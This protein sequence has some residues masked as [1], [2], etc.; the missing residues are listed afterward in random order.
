MNRGRTNATSLVHRRIILLPFLALYVSMAVAQTKPFTND[1]ATFLQDITAFMVE[2]DKKEGKPFMEQEFAP[3]W[4]GTFFGAPQRSRVVELANVML[5]K[6][7]EAFPGFRDYLGSLVAFAGGGRSAADFDTYMT[8]LE[9]A[10]KSSRKQNLTDLIS[11]SANLFKDNTLYKSARVQWQSSNGGFTFAYDSV[12][13]VIFSRLDLRC[14]AKGDSA[15]VR[16]TSGTYYPT[17]GIWRG[18]GGRITW[19][20]A[21]L[22]P[23]ATFAEWDHGY[24][25]RVKSSEIEVDSVRFNDPY[26]DNAL[27][28]RVTDKVL[29]NVTEE[30]ATYPRFESYDRRK[31]IRDIMEGIDF[32]GGFSFQGAKLQG[33]GTREEPAFLTF[34]KDKQPFIITRGLVYTIEPDKINGEDV[35]VSIRLDKDS[36]SHPNVNVRFR[37]DKRQLTVIKQDEGLS[38]APFYDSFHKLDMHFEELRWKQ[39]DPL[40]EIS[41]LQGSSQTKTVFES[42]NFFKRARYESMLG[43]DAVHP[44]S[45]LREFNKKVGDHFSATE[46][47]VHT[48]LQKPQVVPLLFDMAV[49]RYIEYDPETEMVHVLPRL[50]EHVLA[51]AKKID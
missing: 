25:V 8:C 47:A 24:S 38:L 35:A 28:G 43:T 30:K 22:K 1:Q 10:A 36:I 18:Q 2:A 12:P 49:K 14:L 40:L 16:N 42:N 37:K 11:M 29:A 15:V 27:L 50:G 41:N 9:S 4:N 46:F 6:R 7:F 45:R 21:G 51:S 34:Y 39:G 26:F 17:Q 5:K 33:Y 31:K 13:K 23:T 3:A 32:E 48:R 20:R 19:E 44:L